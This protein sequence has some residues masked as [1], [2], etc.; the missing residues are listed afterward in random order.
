MENSAITKKERKEARRKEADSKAQ[1]DRSESRM[2]RMGLKSIWLLI[3]LVVV[4]GVVWVVMNREPSYSGGVVHWH[5]SIHVY[6]CGVERPLPTTG[7]GDHVGNALLHHHND[8]TI[9]VEGVVPREEDI[10][11]GAFFDAI[12]IPFSRTKIFDMENDHGCNDGK[13]NQVHLLV[14]GTESEEF[15]NVIV[16][17]GDKFEVRYE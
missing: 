8:Q 12:D 15:R 17:D 4:G 10:S 11:L 1:R 6:I 3:G 16:H 7:S 14:N 2:R 13:D 5:A 9:H